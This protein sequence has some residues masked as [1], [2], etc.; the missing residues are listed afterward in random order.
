MLEELST[1]NKIVGVKQLRK[2]LSLGTVKRVYI[3]RDA[4]IR[5]VQPI[6]EQCV[7]EGIEVEYVPSMKLLGEACKITVEA[8]V[9]AIL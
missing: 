4:D 1:A 3:A 7:E 9:A 8:A 5:L 2:A 6:F